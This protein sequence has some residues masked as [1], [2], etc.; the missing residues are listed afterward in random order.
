MSTTHHT[1]RTRNSNYFP[2][3]PS[4]QK[5]RCFIGASLCSALPTNSNDQEQSPS[6]NQ[7][8]DDNLVMEVLKTVE[9]SEHIERNSDNNTNNDNPRSKETQ[10]NDFLDVGREEEKVIP[11]LSPLQE[12]ERDV[13]IVINNLTAG[14]DT[15][16]YPC[17]FLC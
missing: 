14:E 10:H 5:S 13:S 9:A 15:S 17:E 7:K 2:P 6:N 1:R 4:S 16:I 11:A 3:L 12:L 8:S